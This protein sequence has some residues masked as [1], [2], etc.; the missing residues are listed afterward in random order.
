MKDAPLTT[1]PLALVSKLIAGHARYTVEQVP[2]LRPLHHREGADDK[3]HHVFPQHG[4]FKQ[5]GTTHLR[6]SL[7]SGL[8]GGE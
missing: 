2:E 3:I 4:I 5:L 1:Y 8:S 7:D 6:G